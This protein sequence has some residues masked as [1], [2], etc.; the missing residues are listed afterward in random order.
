MTVHR[1]VIRMWTTSLW[2]AIC[3]IILTLFKQ[4]PSYIFDF[5]QMIYDVIKWQ[6]Q[7]I[8]SSKFLIQWEVRFVYIYVYIIEQTK[9]FT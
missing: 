6:I 4:S 8:G 1:E 3:I 2:L 7:M 5:K 9:H